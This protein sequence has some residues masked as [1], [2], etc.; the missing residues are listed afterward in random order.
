MC[1]KWDVWGGGGVDRPHRPAP[2][3]KRGRDPAAGDSDAGIFA[4][5]ESVMTTSVCVFP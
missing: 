5:S 4:G 3:K 2:K 1:V